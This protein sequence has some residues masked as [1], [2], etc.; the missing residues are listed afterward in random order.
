MTKSV[1]TAKLL[2]QPPSSQ[3]PQGVKA[4]KRQHAR[5]SAGSDGYGCTC[6]GAWLVSGSVCVLED[7]AVHIS[8]RDGLE[9]P[10]LRGEHDSWVV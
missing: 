10:H 6:G 5:W 3:K 7:G 8:S 1:Q 4:G 9:L 2:E